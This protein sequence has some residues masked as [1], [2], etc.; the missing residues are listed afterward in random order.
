M[1]VCRHEMRLL[2]SFSQNRLLDSTY[3]PFGQSV[4]IRK[5]WNTECPVV[6]WDHFINYD[7]QQ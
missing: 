7:A 3:N 5:S 2:D 6:S 1:R 4:C